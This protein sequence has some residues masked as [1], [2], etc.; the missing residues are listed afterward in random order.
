MEELTLDEIKKIEIDLLIQLDK[1]CSFYGIRYF[2][3]AGT[4]L[5]AARHN[6]F[7]PWDDD[8][9]ITMPRNDYNKFIELAKVEDL[10]FDFYCHERN[11]N[12]SYAYGKICDRRTTLIEEN[13]NNAEMGIY[14]DIF[15]I[16]N[17][18]DNQVKSK[19]YVKKCHFYSW[20]CFMSIE[21]KY[22]PAKSSRLAKIAKKIIYP[23]VKMIGNDYWVKKLSTLS[24]KYAE[25]T[26]S[27]YVSNVLSPNYVHVFERS[28][29]ELTDR[30]NFEGHDFPVPVGWDKLLRCMYKDYMQLPPK[31]KQIS[32]HDYIAYYK[33][34]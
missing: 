8:V 17:L 31:E 33:D 4:L 28:W 2:L 20:L 21:K 1:V 3:H 9:D 22:K 12:Y 11:K 16:D 30:L 7:I 34:E 26:N 6:G 14:I 24:Q 10:G 27:K 13:F 15:P 32:H 18:L 19:K 29:F 23:F 5:G 25:N